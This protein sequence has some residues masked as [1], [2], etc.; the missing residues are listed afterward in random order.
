MTFVDIIAA[1][2]K[3]AAYTVG[4]TVACIATGFTV[5]L[6]VAVIRRLGWRFAAPLT[7]VYLAVFRGVPMLVLLFMVFFGLPSLGIQVPPLAAMMLSLGLISG[8]YLSE[9]FRGALNAVEPDEI[10][11]AQ[12]MGLT[13]WQTLRCIELPQ[14]LRASVPGM[15][16]EFTTV[17]KYSPFAY[18]VGIPEIMKQATALVST[19]MRG[20]EI[21][22]AVGLMYFSIYWMLVL[23]VWTIE[24][25]F[26]VPG[27]THR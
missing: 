22:L 18:T 24:R 4:V 19:T 27:L 26:R 7:N 12:A 8:A 15:I 9:V 5:G 25:C 14:M 20:V 13:R 10:L 3:G 2:S 11:A 6:A 21:Y 17:L 1:L 16:N 23:G